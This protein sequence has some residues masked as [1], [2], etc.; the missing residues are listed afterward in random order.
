MTA[1]EGA[2]VPCIGQAIA[3]IVDTRLAGTV[4]SAEAQR[5][6]AAI[7]R[8]TAGQMASTDNDNRRGN[9]IA[10]TS[11]RRRQAATDGLHWSAVRAV[12]HSVPCAGMQA[13]THTRSPRADRGY[14][15]AAWA[16]G[17]EAIEWNRLLFADNVI[18]EG[19]FRQWHCQP[20]AG[21]AWIYARYAV[22]AV[23]NGIAA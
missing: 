8:A 6:R 18:S 1:R 5:S 22:V 12:L 11:W 9:S 17:N 10:L 4:G 14:Q 7:G 2:P 15:T 16:A 13:M 23:D 20:T 3:A 21:N 19:A